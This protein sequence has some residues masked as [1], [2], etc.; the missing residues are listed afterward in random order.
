[1]V[2]ELIS[3]LKNKESTLALYNGQ[4]FREWIDHFLMEITD[5]GIDSTLM[6]FPSGEEIFFENEL[7][8]LNELLE[9]LFGVLREIDVPIDMKIAEKSAEPLKIHFFGIVDT[10]KELISATNSGDIKKFDK[11][12]EECIEHAKSLYVL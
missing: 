8:E 10:V 11:V 2:S 9:F 3:E 5:Y 7:N 12:L 1:M 4:K 6:I